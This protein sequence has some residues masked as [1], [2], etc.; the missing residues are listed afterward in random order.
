MFKYGLI[1]NKIA[2]EKTKLNPQSLYARQKIKIEKY[3][4]NQ[5]DKL[6]SYLYI[7]IATAFGSSGRPRFDLTVNEFVLMAIQKNN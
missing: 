6:I 2:N 5:N 4:I 7:K 1:K 3:L